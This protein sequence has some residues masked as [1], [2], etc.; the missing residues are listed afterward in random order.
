MIPPKDSTA[1][2]LGPSAHC[3]ESLPT[4]AK[5]SSV[6]IH[7]PSAH[8]FQAFDELLL[9]SLEGKT[10]YFGKIGD[11]SKT[12]TSYFQR[13]GARSCGGRENPAEW[14]LEVTGAATTTGS[15]NTK[16][17]AAIWSN[18]DERTA[19]KAELARMK[20]DFSRQPV[21][22]DDP[23]DPDALRPFAAPFETQF[24]IVLKRVSQQYWRTPSYLY[25]KVALCLFSVSVLIKSTTMPRRKNH[26]VSNVIHSRHYSSASP[27]GKCRIRSKGFRTRCLPSSCCW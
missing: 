6:T 2:P 19:I 24:W 11:S 8:L 12:V 16:D 7:Q 10:L 3:F 15:E 9:L 5:P 23:D 4:T 17:W 27:F 14:M 21:S 18:S 1:R 26:R 25:S 22:V 13:R 20:T